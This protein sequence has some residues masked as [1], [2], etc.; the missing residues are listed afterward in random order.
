LCARTK[1]PACRNQ[2]Q[3]SRGGRALIGSKVIC[4]GQDKK[5]GK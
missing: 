1:K 3:P 5:M 2:H 4:L